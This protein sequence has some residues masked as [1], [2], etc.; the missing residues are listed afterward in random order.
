[1]VV[2]KILILDSVTQEENQVEVIRLVLQDRIA[3]VVL[4]LPLVV[5]VAVMEVR[6][7]IFLLN[8]TL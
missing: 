6:K 8:K 3:T 2:I 7:Q 5:V 4:V 1:M